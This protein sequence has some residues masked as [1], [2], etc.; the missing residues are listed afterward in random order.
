MR[1]RVTGARGEAGASH[2]KFDIVLF[3]GDMGGK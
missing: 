2:F 3:D 1:V